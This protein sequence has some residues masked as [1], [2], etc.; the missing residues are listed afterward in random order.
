VDDR[1]R[2]Q[3]AGAVVSDLAAA[4]DA[5]HLDAAFLEEG[6]R[7]ED[8]RIVGLAAKGEDRR[9]L[10]EQE[11]VADAP[12]GTGSGQ[13]L[14]EIPRRPVRDPPQPV[15]DQR[16]HRAHD[17]SRWFA[18]PWRGQPQ[19]VRGMSAPTAERGGAGE[20]LSPRTIEEA[21]LEGLRAASGV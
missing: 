3:L 12:L 14:L 11:L 17:T 13:P 6:G 9:V 5:E 4:L 10:E 21:V 8:V 7:R 18:G 15:R 19:L 2:H 1:V 16:L 20:V